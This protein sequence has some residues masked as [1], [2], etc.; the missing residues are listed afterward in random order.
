[1]DTKKREISVE[2]AS[3]NDDEIMFYLN[4]QVGFYVKGTY[5]NNNSIYISIE[6]EK[7]D[8]P[9]KEFRKSFNILL[10][11]IFLISL[12]MLFIL[13]FLVLNF[14]LFSLFSIYF[15]LSFTLST[16]IPLLFIFSL[17]V[18]TA[19]ALYSD[20]LKN[21]HTAEH[22]MGNFIDNYQRLPISTE[23]L[24]KSSRFHKNCGSLAIFKDFLRLLHISI[25]LYG[26]LLFYAVV[27][28]FDESISLQE[29]IFSSIML[30]AIIILLKILLEKKSYL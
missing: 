19:S 8:L 12:K 27:V 22:L 6:S 20:K 13:I 4:S 2:H 30:I 14:S 1:M 11:R 25:Y 26:S 15:F 24:R 7:H 16:T 23:E 29:K 3:S 17:Y 9:S 10:Q 5:V 21:N 18:R 28:F